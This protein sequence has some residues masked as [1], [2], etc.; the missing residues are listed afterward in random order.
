MLG[1]KWGRFVYWA[2]QNSAAIQALTA[3]ATILLM[4]L[5]AAITYRYMVLT[6][7]QVRTSR[8]QLMLLA[9]PNILVETKVGAGMKQFA[10][11]IY[12]KGAYPFRLRNVEVHAQD[13]DGEEFTLRLRELHYAVVGAG[14]CAHTHESV[15]DKNV[16]EERLLCGAFEDFLYIEFDC[17]DLMELASR[18]YV[19]SRI[20]GMKEVG[21]PRAK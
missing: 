16:S 6:R 10:V 11:N 13:E 5:L 2:T 18:R 7:K 21:A 19:Y 20:N 3:S 8:R 15:Y 1:D 4:I 14:D 9:Q 17:E 12:N